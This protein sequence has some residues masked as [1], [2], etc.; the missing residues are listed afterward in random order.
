[1]T[2][3]LALIA[4]L[5]GGGAGFIVGLLIGGVLASSL[6]ISGFEGGAGHFSALV[7][8]AMGTV[9]LLLGVMLVL[10]KRR[11]HRRFGSLLG[12]TVIILLAMGGLAT[13]GV[14]MRLATLDHFEGPHPQLEFEIRLPAK[15]AI[16]DRKAIDIELHTNKNTSGAMLA[17][18]WLRHEDGRAVIAG[19][20]PLHLK[21]SDRIVVLSLPDQPKRLFRLRLKRTP[22]VAADF[23]EWRRVDLIDDPREAAG[24]Q[25]PGKNDN[26]EIRIRVPDWEPPVPVASCA[27]A[28]QL[29]S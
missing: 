28:G 16:P 25:A 20:I 23:G 10:H 1:M 2:H 14:Y 6:G 8:L 13:A 27:L 18:Q 4:G 7:G 12:H 17:E 21:T 15:A 29:C 9:G 3:L 5:A 24:P 26:F 11:R 22:N 19:T